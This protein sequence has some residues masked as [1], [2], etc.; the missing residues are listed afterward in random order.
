MFSLYA[1]RPRRCIQHIPSQPGVQHSNAPARPSVSFLNDMDIEV[2]KTALHTE[3][4]GECSDCI[5]RGAGL[6]R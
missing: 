3:L 1:H 4:E 2:L 5:P 6:T